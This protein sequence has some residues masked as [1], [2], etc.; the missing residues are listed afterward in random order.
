VREVSAKAVRSIL[1]VLEEAGV[2]VDAHLA[3][4]AFPIQQLREPG[5]RIDWDIF[6]TFV[7]GLEAVCGTTLSLEEIGARVL[8]VPSFQFLQLAA[9]LVI[10]PKHL[11]A[12][13]NRMV[14][15]AMFSNVTVTT[16]W[17]PTGRVAVTGE[18]MPGYRESL[19]FHRICHG[20]VAALPKLL[21]LP[22]SKIEDQRL[23]AR[24]AR[25]VL[26]P[27]GSHTLAAK[28]RRGAR[29]CFALGDV[30]RGVVRQQ[31]ELEG[32]V[33][34]LRTSRHELRQLIERLP[35]GVLI[36]RGGIVAWAN[37]SMLESLGY[38]TLDEVLG[39]NILDFLPAEDRELLM[40]A[41]A[42]AQGNEAIDARLEGTR[43]VRPDGTT[44]ILHASAVQH[45]EFEG[46]MSRLVVLR[47]VTEQHRLRDQLAIAER[48]A[49]LG[50]LA[51]GIAHEINNPLAYTHTSIEVALREVAALSS[52]LRTSKLEETLVRARE[53]AERVRGIVRDMKVFTRAD[54][55]P[56]EAVDL[57]AVL[58]STL[59]LAA[60][61]IAPRARVIRRYGHAPR[62]RA[63]QGRL[64]QLFL[65]LVLNAVD[66][67][68]DGHADRN[69]I[70]VTI[71]SDPTGRAVV[72]IADTGVGIATGH[73]R[74]VFEPFYTT[75]GV[76][77]GTGLGLSICHGIVTQLGGEI[78][79]D[80]SPGNGTTFRVVLP[81]S[82][83]TPVPAHP[84]A[85]APGRGRLLV[86]DDEAELLHSIDAL[87]GDVHDVV[88]ASS[89]RQA[90]ELLRSDRGFDV[91]LTDLMM[92]D[93]T[94]MDL[95]EALRADYP[96]LEQQVVF[97][98]GG[99]FTPRGRKLLASVPNRCLEKPFDADEL[100]R[101]VSELIARR[102][103][104]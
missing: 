33:A 97:M 32:S 35:E 99:A 46:V 19:A 93:V 1:E 20:N 39:R 8:R 4:I 41:M 61:A 43:V 40:K 90:L 45:V 57:A 70:R 36:H 98:T 95:F 25:V 65:N 16:Q 27:P 66:A 67:I 37:A 83:A 12:V 103:A 17:L 53:G 68:P 78:S 28:I 44:R 102:G 23:G 71:T 52:P 79:F 48:M 89:G 24:R 14:A 85:R 13:A 73:Q 96:G 30:V 84:T 34:A 104:N 60:N 86:I 64:G 11:Y 92:A 10:R 81:A 3:R 2:P 6:V 101:T 87:L 15:P 100:L 22:A 9:K 42:T 49:L 5:A 50:R 55:E 94:G 51:A 63:T 26:L 29:A 72:E 82:D 47:D 58:D 38:A 59:A 75:K 74:H 62:A 31:N 91:I 18:I 88:T 76:G 54:G 80:S 7:D 56:S 21:D 69:E 77:A